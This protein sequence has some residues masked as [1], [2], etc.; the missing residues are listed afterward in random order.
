VNAEHPAELHASTFQRYCLP[1]LRLAV[2]DVPLT[3]LS[4]TSTPLAMSLT[5]TS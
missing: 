1:G 2:N 5:A 4:T 3:M